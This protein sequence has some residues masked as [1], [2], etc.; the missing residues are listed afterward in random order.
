MKR[1]KSGSQAWGPQ[2]KAHD[3]ERPTPTGHLTQAE[4]DAMDD[5][6]CKKAAMLLLLPIFVIPLRVVIG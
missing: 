1:V 6:G 5:K 3:V 2:N 4:I